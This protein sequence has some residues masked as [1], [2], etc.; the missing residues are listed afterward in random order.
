MIA[1]EGSSKYREQVERACGAAGIRHTFRD[2]ADPAERPSIYAACDA[3]IMTSVQLPESVEGFGISYLEASMFEKPVVGFRT[4]GVEEAVKHDRT[5]LLV[6]EGDLPG[7][8]SAVQ[9][10]ILE[11]DLRQRLGRA[12]REFALGFS[13]ENAARALC[14]RVISRSRPP[15]VCARGIPARRK[16]RRCPR[17]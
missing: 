3:F 2:V 17:A 14:E 11:P 5:G 8:A 13:W 6:A 1:G 16:A 15:P 12:G 9:R 10:L 4:G 7:I